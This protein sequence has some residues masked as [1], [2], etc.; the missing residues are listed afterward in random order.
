MMIARDFQPR[1]RLALLTK[2]PR[3]EEQAAAGAGLDL[4]PANPVA[5]PGRGGAG[6]GAA[7]LGCV[8]T[9]GD[10]GAASRGFPPSGD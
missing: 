9:L 2:D 1:F 8:A 4:P 10:V 5:P 7:D 6:P 3:T